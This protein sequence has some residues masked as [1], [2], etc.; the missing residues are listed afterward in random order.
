MQDNNNDKMDH[1][2]VSEHFWIPDVDVKPNSK[3]DMQLCTGIKYEAGS[4]AK[5]SVLIN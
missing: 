2:Y 5:L 1:E 4:C 3:S